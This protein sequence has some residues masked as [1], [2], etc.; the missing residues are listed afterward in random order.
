MPI[1]M[2]LGNMTKPMTIKHFK[3]TKEL[4]NKPIELM[5]LK[6]VNGKYFQLII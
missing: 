2:H 4:L 3:D 1:S 5:I 6:M